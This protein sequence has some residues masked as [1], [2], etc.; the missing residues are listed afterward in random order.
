MS[1]HL[2]V[3]ALDPGV[4]ASFSPT[5][6]G[7]LLRGQL[8]FQGVVITDALNMKPA[9]AWAPGEAAVRAFLA[10]NDILLMPPDLAAAQKGLLDA[11]A[12]GRIPRPQMVESVTRILAL[13]QRLAGFPRPALGD[14]D[15]GENRAAALVVAQMA[16]TVLRGPCAGPLVDGPVRITASNGREQQV[17]WLT[18]ALK[19]R[20]FP[21]VTRGGHRVHLVGHL[22][23]PADLVPDA[24][25]TVAMDTPFLLAAAT[26]PVRVATYSSTQAA[27][28]ALAA[29]IAGVIP[30]TGRSPVPV[31]GLPRSAG[32]PT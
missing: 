9:M 2:D 20:G 23:G 11:L 12:S 29:T 6:L 19:A 27:M 13:K 17:T 32:G 25:V 10:G 24:A 8:G 30:A 21:V 26:S 22:D 15:T 16:V 1:G 3:E 28:L 18:D 7:G 14:M 5:I 4:P 31:D